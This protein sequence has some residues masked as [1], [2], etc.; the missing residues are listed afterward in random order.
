MLELFG[1]I[2]VW[3]TVAVV[4]IG[5][6]I[7]IIVSTISPHFLQGKSKNPSLEKAGTRRAE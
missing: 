1:V 5:T 7:M 4:V 6:L 3:L 2:V